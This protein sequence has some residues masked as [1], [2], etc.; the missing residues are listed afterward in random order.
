MNRPPFFTKGM[1]ARYS[2]LLSLI[3]SVSK[4]GLLLGL[5]NSYRSKKPLVRQRG[6]AAEQQG[7]ERQLLIHAG[8]GKAPQ[9]AGGIQQLE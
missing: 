5:R 7:L 1:Y 4:P 6:V 8:R 2:A 3:V 9:L